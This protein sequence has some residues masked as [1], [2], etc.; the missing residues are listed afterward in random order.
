MWS[1]ARNCPSHCMCRRRNCTECQRDVKNRL[2]SSQRLSEKKESVQRIYAHFLHRN[3]CDR[4]RR[5]CN[6]CGIHQTSPVC[7]YTRRLPLKRRRVNARENC[8]HSRKCVDISALYNDASVR[9]DCHRF[10]SNHTP[11]FEGAGPEASNC[12]KTS[13]FSNV[14]SVA[15]AMTS[16]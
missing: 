15:K 3:R 6:I 9:T 2:R 7:T 8:S 14:Q 12:L 16:F 10:P 5:R 13:T 11:P 4:C 1:N